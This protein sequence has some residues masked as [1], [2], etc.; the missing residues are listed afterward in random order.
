MA[1]NDWSC[2]K[3]KLHIIRSINKIAIAWS[4]ALVL[5]DFA[6]FVHKAGIADDGTLRLCN[7]YVLYS[8]VRYI[9]F[10]LLNVLAFLSIVY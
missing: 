2:A 8:F 3:L 4:I 10:V 6:W 5:L 9:A 7:V 1:T